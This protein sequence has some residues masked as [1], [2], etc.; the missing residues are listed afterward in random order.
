MRAQSGHDVG[1]VDEQRKSGSCLDAREQLS[2]R[3]RQRTRP[4]GIAPQRPLLNE[5][6]NGN[7]VGLVDMMNLR[8]YPRLRCDPQRDILMRIAQR[9]WMSLEPQQK[10]AVTEVKL[11]CGCTGGSAGNGSHRGHLS[12]A[13]GGDNRCPNGLAILLGK[14]LQ[15][16]FDHEPWLLQALDRCSAFRRIQPASA[17]DAH[18]SQHKTGATRTADAVAEIVGRRAR[19]R[20]D[21]YL[22]EHPRSPGAHE[23]SQKTRVLIAD[24]V[25]QAL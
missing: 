12:G 9:T 25:A 4:A 24:D 8:R 1:V 11:K 7:A 20:A 5:I 15:C 22:V 14:S 10:P 16:R 13:K 17:P 2:Q 18:V 19:V 21:P 6:H 3:L 23:G